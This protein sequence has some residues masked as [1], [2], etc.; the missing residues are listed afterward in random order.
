MVAKEDYKTA[1]RYYNKVLK[2][3]PDNYIAIR[4]GILAS[5]KVRNVK[6][7]KK[8]LEMMVKHGPEKESMQAQSRLKALGG[9]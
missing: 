5:R 8:Y 9:K 4:N 6:Q 7:E 1:C 2:A 3:E